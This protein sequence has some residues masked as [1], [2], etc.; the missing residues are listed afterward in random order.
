MGGGGNW[1][2]ELYDNNRSTTFV[3]DGVLNIKPVPTADKIGEAGVRNGHTMNMWGGAPADYCTANAFYGCE[4]SSNGQNYINPIM[5][6]RLTTVNSLKIRFGRVEVKAKLPKGNWLWPAIWMMPTRNEYG[7]W[8]AS[9][10]IDIM[11]SRGNVGYPKSAGGGVESYGSTLH[12]GPD[13]SKNQYA[14]THAEYSLNSG[15][16]NDAFH[17]FGL[18]WDDKVLYTYLDNDSNRVLQVDHS[19]QSYW[20]KSGIKDMSNP[21][22]YS[23]NKC[24]PFDTEFYLILN[25]AVGGVNGYFPDGVG[26][27]PWSDSSSRAAADFW[28]NKGTWWNTWSDA[29]AFQIDSV[30]VWDLSNG[31]EEVVEDKKIVTE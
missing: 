19:A 20:D 18:Y 1:E 2:F 17:T 6:G 23:K 30:K 8:P 10:E 9:G 22:Q 15:T 14:K 28:D 29:S 21:W 16:F 31:E 5:S 27:K 24:A 25:L 11:E 7:S 3:K 12:W 4:R 26:G 13:W